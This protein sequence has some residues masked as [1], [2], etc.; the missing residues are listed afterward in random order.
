MALT[1]KQ[2]IMEHKKRKE[3]SKPQKENTVE[4]IPDNSKKFAADITACLEV[5]KAGG[6]ILYPTDTIW[7]IG[8]DA[9]NEKAVKKIF[10]LKKRDEQESM[11]L[12]VEHINRIGRHVKQIPDA[13]IQLVEV[14]DKPM[15]IVYPGAVNVTPELISEDG[16][17]GIQITNDEFC[18]KLISALNKPLV[19]T[20][21]NIS[22]EDYPEIYKEIPDEIKNGVDYIVKWRQ[23]DPNPG[24][25]S[26]VIK[27]G[28]KGEVEILRK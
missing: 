26:S 21:A 15:T 18:R 7:G 9:T 19:Y 22:G 14:T 24:T 6:I 25:P 3:F 28:I 17:V 1:D 16:S 13:A 20:S 23:K 10:D 27:V 12:L 4:Q 5:L 2:T 8:C 11:L